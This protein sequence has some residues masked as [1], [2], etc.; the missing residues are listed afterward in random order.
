LG[1]FDIQVE[2]YGH[3]YNS[4]LLEDAKMGRLKTSSDYVHSVED[5]LSYEENLMKNRRRGFLE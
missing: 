5:N 1:S 2:K 3:I 4:R